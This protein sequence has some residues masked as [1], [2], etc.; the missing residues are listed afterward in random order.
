[1]IFSG[2]R[3]VHDS[4]ALRLKAINPAVDHRHYREMVH[5]WP[6]SPLREGRQALDEATAFIR[7]H[8]H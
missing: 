8:S 6:V 2:D 7:L 4:D 3:E 5:V 1:M